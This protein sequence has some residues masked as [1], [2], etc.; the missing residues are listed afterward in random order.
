V[1][2]HLYT[3]V[4]SLCRNRKDF[5]S[6]FT[7]FVHPLSPLPTFILPSQPSQRWNRFSSMGSR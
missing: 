3:L 6:M 5:P 1:R 7:A 4:F 2:W